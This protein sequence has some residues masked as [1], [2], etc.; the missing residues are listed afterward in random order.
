MGIGASALFSIAAL[1]LG[2]L[3][4]TLIEPRITGRGE[5][6]TRPLI[7]RIDKKPMRPDP[8]MYTAAPFVALLGA[9]FAM[10][11]IPFGPTLVGA[12]LGIGLFYFLVVVDFVVL[13]VALG[14]YG[15]DTPASI[16]ACYRMVAQLIAYVVP[17]GLA[18][19]GPIMMARSLSIVHIV[20]AQRTAGLWYVAAQ[21]LGFLLYLVTALMQSYRAPFLE[22]FAARIEGGVLGVYGGYKAVMW[23]LALSGLLFLVAAMGAALFLG[24]Y[25][26]PLFPGPVW[27]L[28][29][30]LAL[31]A[32]MLWLGARARPRSTAEMLAL[33]WKYLI[34]I[35]LLNVLAV[36]A[37]ILLGV[38]QAPFE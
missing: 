37:L 23:R 14:G 35:G 7:V 30:T 19:L 5:G 32:L 27:M 20:D 38:G 6:P 16:E 22:P 15:A 24:G 33:A 26:G 3:F 29:K 2:A 11:V 4:A 31:M 10:V 25:G 9:S 18:V 8:W 21:P 36:G 28:L 1:G 17:L 13:G 12:D 34:P